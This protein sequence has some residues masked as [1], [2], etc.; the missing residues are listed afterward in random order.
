VQLS[1]EGVALHE[2]LCLPGW[3]CHPK[4]ALAAIHPASDHFPDGLLPSA[5]D[6]A[7]P[8]K[9]HLDILDKP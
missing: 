3:S 5:Q 2:L 9:T 1:E 6:Q 7:Q 8:S 4:H